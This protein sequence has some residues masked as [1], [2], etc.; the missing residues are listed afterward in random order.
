ML[1][2]MGVGDQPVWNVRNLPQPPT[3]RMCYS[4][5]DVETSKSL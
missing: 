3:A 2:E 1:I 5:K 4:L